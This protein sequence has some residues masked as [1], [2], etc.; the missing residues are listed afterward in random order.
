MAKTSEITALDAGLVTKSNYR[1]N[2]QVITVTEATGTAGTSYEATGVLPQEAKLIASMIN[3]AGAS[4]IGTTADGSTSIQANQVD[5]TLTINN[6]DVGGK[7][8]T[9]NP[10][11]TGAISGFLLIATN[12]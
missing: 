7:V 10:D 3:G 8:I 1:G 12:E 6:A 9:V 5:N 11:S 4:D 2:V